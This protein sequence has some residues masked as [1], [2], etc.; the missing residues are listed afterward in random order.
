MRDKNWNIERSTPTPP[1]RDVPALRAEI[2]KI[3]GKSA[4]LGF[5]CKKQT[6]PKIVADLQGSG[7]QTGLLRH[8]ML[9]TTLVKFPKA[10]PAGHDLADLIARDQELDAITAYEAALNEHAQ[11][12]RLENHA[13]AV[14]LRLESDTIADAILEA[15]RR[16]GA[17][18]EVVAAAA[19]ISRHDETHRA[20]IDENQGKVDKAQKEGAQERDQLRAAVQQRDA[21]I[22]ELRRQLGLRAA[23]EASLPLPGGGGR[24]TPR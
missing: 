20:K 24:T 5:L 13:R 18:A 9:M 14:N 17:D 8:N 1:A 3:S 10:L 15:A 12:V 19:Q 7:Q 4:A 6:D 11:D 21:E 23:A 2:V 16:P 22:L